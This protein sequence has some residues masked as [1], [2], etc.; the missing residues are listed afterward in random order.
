MPE[1]DILD[2]WWESGVSHVGV[3]KHRA[4][5]D[6][7]RWPA[8]MYLEGSDQHRGWFQSSLLLG[9][10]AFGQSPYKSV[11]CCG[12][13]VDE[14]GE[15]MSK[16]KGNGIAPQEV[17]DKY[18]AD[19][20]R[21]WV[22]STDYSVDVSIGDNI[23]QRTSDAYRRFRNT[24]RF[25]LGNLDGF[26]FKRDAVSLDEM[27]PVD[28]WAMLRLKQL[29]DDVERGYNEYHF[30]QVFR[31][32][33]DYVVGDLSSVYMD[34]VKD[35]LYAEAPSSVARRSAQTVLM[36]ILEVLVRVMS[37]ILSFTCDEVWEHY[38]ETER[39]RE[40][41][42]VSVQLAGW[43]EAADFIPALPQG[44]AAEAVMANFACLLEVRDAVTKAIEEARNAK[45]VGKSQ[46][47]VLKITVSQAVADVLG[48]Y[49]AADLEELFIVSHV[50]VVAGDVEEA[51][52]EV[53]ATS[54]P[55]CPRC[56][57]H[58]ELG[59]NANHAEVCKRCGDVLDQLA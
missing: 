23:L 44:E 8:D 57:N 19:V 31:A 1:K 27:R 59:G 6:H 51:L 13:T 5:A 41:R 46:E 2:V 36:N 54:E 58:R 53:S 3:L 47:A 7:L 48:A 56:W 26:D 22:A 43:P 18:G 38:P 10:G 40:G 28:V 33:Y 20:L 55:K 30:H 29:L 50:D 16:S 17:I 49:D 52:V 35:R 12:F 42:P 34:V 4:E 9:T 21:L 37:P 14:N 39:N 15:K 25:L 11:M 24:F 32:L 45:T